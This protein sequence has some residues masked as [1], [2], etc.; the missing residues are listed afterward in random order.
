MKTQDHIILDEKCRILDC[1]KNTVPLTDLKYIVMHY[2]AST[3]MSSAARYLS[4][5]KNEVSAHLIID[6]NGDIIQLVPFNI[7]AWHAGRSQYKNDIHINKYSI[8]IELVNA[9]KLTLIGKKYYTALG[10]QIPVE[11]VVIHESEDKI[12]SYWHA[13][14]EE[15]I[16][17][18][19][20][21]CKLLKQDYPQIQEIIGHSDITNRKIDPGKAFPWDKIKSI[22]EIK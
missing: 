17:S 10:T 13:Y 4:N 5:P 15:Q 8:G 3:T 16:T 22:T 6:K 7:Q 1:P 11:Q 19:I 12:L 2:T 9:G 18:L 21:V 14:P 20:Q